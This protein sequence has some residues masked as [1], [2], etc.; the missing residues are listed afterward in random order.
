VVNVELEQPVDVA[1]GSTLELTLSIDLSG[2]FANAGGT[3]LVDPVQ[4]LDGQPLESMVEQNIRSSFHA[5]EDEN[6]DGA[7]D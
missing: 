3:G 2:W 6:G 5:F 4:A 1:E 7:A